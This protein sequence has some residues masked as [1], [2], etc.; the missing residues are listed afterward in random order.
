MSLVLEEIKR[1]VVEKEYRE[2]PTSLDKA[3]WI[4]MNYAGEVEITKKNLLD[5]FDLTKMASQRRV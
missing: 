1:H 3:A 2:Q 5:Y 4:L